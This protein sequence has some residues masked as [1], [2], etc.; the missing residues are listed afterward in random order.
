MPIRE[1]AAVDEEKGCLYCLEGFEEVESIDAPPVESCPICHQ[2][3]VRQLSAP[4]L[5]R[6]QTG[7]DDSAKSA[8][9]SKLKRLGKGEYEREY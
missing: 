1:Y 7:F 5:G 3:V 9:F 2:P 6:S 8:G 4:R